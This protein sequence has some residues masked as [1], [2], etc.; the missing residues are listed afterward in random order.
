M[1]ESEEY[2]QMRADEVKLE[3]EVMSAIEQ[4][5]QGSAW[6]S[7]DAMLK[8]VLVV[9]TFVDSDN[10]HVTTWLTTNSWLTAEGMARRV[11]RDVEA[12]DRLRYED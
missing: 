6:S 10:D 9:M 2:R 3:D 12:R 8:D 1:S 4:V 11:I 7:P 5:V